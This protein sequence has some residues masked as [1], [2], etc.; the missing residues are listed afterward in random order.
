MQLSDTLGLKHYVCRCDCLRDGEVGRVDLPPYTS[1]S[2]RRL[3]IVREGA[4]H[5]RRIGSELASA[6]GD[7]P[8][9]RRCTSRAVLNVRI[10]LRQVVEG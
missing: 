2:R 5:V 7:V 6:S 4:I 8:L 9:S 3:R 1:A 10:C